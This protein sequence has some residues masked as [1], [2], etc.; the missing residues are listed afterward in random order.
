MAR[1]E[2][3]ELILDA[4]QEAFAELDFRSVPMETIA[5][6]SGVTKA[7]LYQYFG[8]KDRLYELCVER[9]RAGL[10]DELEQRVGE[11]EPGWE[12]LRVFV[13]HYFDYL[14]ANRATSWL[15]YGEA[16]RAVVDDMRERNARSL[17][18]IF[19]EAAEE[20]GRVPDPVAI[21]VL[22]HGLVG[23]G[24]QA[25]RWW[26]GQKKVSKGEAVGRFLSQARGTVTAAFA[27]MDLKESS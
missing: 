9:A 11:A 2:R 1:E 26:I 4:A 17:A 18:R 8:S 24:E 7:L 22:A 27:A 16:S 23:A 12:K 5:E 10:F 25:G 20:A 19:T 21:Q 13:E 3:E 15:L 14:E 6:R